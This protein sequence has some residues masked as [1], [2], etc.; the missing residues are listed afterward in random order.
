MPQRPEQDN[1]RKDCTSQVTGG[2]LFAAC[3]DM[4]T[5][6]VSPQICNRRMHEVLVL[7]CAE[8]TRRSAMS[9]GS[10][11]AQVD[12]LCKRCGVAT[13]DKAAIQTMRRHSNGSAPLDRAELLYDLRALALFISAVFAAGV[14]GRLLAVLPPHNRPAQKAAPADV[15]RL[16]CI[17]DGWD[18]TY[19]YMTTDDECGGQ[20]VRTDYTDCADGRDNTYL[21]RLLAKGMQLNL[22]DCRADGDCIRPDLVV[23]EPDFLVDI[24]SVAACFS[25]YGHSPLA[26]TVNRM[27]PRANSQP[28]LL[29]NFA[30]SALDNIINNG[31]FNLHD[32]IT[33]S[34]KSQAMQFC[35]CPS[36]NAREFVNAA[37]TQADNLREVVETLFSRPAEGRLEGYD[38]SKAMLEPS[39]VCESLG[40][41]G[42]AD[43]MTTDMKL[44]VEQKSGRL[45]SPGFGRS[46]SKMRYQESHYV[47]LLLYYGVLRY[48]YG[49]TD[50][51]VDMRLLYSKYRAADGLLAVNFYKGLFREAIKLRNRIVAGEFVMGNGGFAAVMDRLGADAINETGVHDRLFEGFIR[52]QTEAVT[53]P[54]HRMQPVERAYFVRMATF[55]YRE[56]LAQKVGSQEGV[57]GS[58][59]DLWNMPLAE[60]QDTGNIY[61][62]LHITG[63]RCSTGYSGF[64]LFTLAVPDY[65]TDFLPNFRRGDM[66]YMYAYDGVPDVRRSVLH[67]GI[68]CETGTDSITVRLTNGQQNPALFG[69]GTYAVEHGGADGAANSML[70]SLHSFIT[71]PKS[72]RDLLLGQRV[73]AADTALTLTRS[74]HPSYDEVL[75][76]A[77]QARD[78]YLLMGPPGTGKTSMALRF[79][80]EEELSDGASSILITA[81]TNRAVDEICAML[82][83]SGIGFLRIG[84]ESSC[85]PR[86]ANHLLEAALGASPKLEDIR[87][88]IVDERVVVATTSTLLAR[89]F[90]FALKKFTLTVVDEASQILEPAIVGLLTGRFILIGDHKQLPAVVAQGEA[91]S[92]VSDAILRGIGLEDCRQS[93][94]ER[95]LRWEKRC[96]RTRFVGVLRRQGRMHPDI[97]AFPNEMF[98]RNE[99]LEPVPCDHQTETSLGYD[100]AP[101]DALDRIL[102]RERMVFLPVEPPLPGEDGGGLKS[103]VAE[104]RVVADILRRIVRFYGRRFDP[105]ATVGVIVPYRNQIAMIRRETE[106]LGLSGLSGVSID[107]V[108]RYQGSQRDVI[109][110]SFT[111]TKPYQLAF[112]TANTFTEDGRLID[113]KLNVAI[114]RA[115]RQM[116][117]TGCER[118]LQANPLFA[119]L[120]ERYAAR[121]GHGGNPAE[122]R[123]ET[124]GIQK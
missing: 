118:V 111:V 13:P 83:R 48:N 7:A 24:S 69:E 31:D 57:A 80:V 18:D 89:P 109:I 103:N 72:C 5:G 102:Q 61:T 34:F 75:L 59:A 93:L 106:K 113:R 90:V 2:E 101:Q 82:D 8:G 91:E 50:K 100:A 99:R 122:E 16:R 73:P 94:F 115:R 58:V 22:L 95:L 43:L 49:V 12:Y 84:N 116:I 4:A 51:T 110:Y 56:Q 86:F 81:Y 121:P 37:K 114:T 32:T 35:S 77:K 53:A 52:P 112:L 29:G 11:F 76:R 71:S 104:A 39:F 107:T 47:Q 42:R 67:R 87:R 74:Y 105:L 30:G 79:L 14:P 66:V 98:Y 63:K 25:D 92:A 85:D 68:L 88:R 117:M 15:K 26:Y 64:D 9:F 41:Q 78:Y 23:V 10:L 40:L 55:T 17:V 46:A 6:A 60:K 20:P 19:I 54:L 108:E 65:G 27:R 21:R 123:L 97:A 119:E 33:N 38:R 70:R 62:G 36:F 124:N 96:G 1:N 3:L 120:M 44:L 28:I 45:P